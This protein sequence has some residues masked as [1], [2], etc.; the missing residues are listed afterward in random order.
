MFGSQAGWIP[1]SLRTPLVV[2]NRFDAYGKRKRKSES[3]QRKVDD[4]DKLDVTSSANIG[5][6]MCSDPVKASC[7]YTFKCALARHLHHLPAMP[8][9]Y[10]STRAS[11]LRFALLPQF[12][13]G[14]SSQAPTTFAVVATNFGSCSRGAT[15]VT[16]RRIPSP[17]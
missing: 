11:L 3:K 10:L 7:W 13:C 14:L 2:Q 4:D 16:Q 8:T 6:L 17:W 9:L 15:C 5:A 1:K 12:L